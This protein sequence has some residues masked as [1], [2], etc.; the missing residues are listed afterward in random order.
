MASLSSEIQ[1]LFWN[2]YHDSRG[3]SAAEILLL[4]IKKPQSIYCTNYFH[5]FSTIN[6]CNIL[7]ST[8]GFTFVT[9]C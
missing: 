9:K 8:V 5:D 6:V 3:W 4:K 7:Y 2:D 1:T